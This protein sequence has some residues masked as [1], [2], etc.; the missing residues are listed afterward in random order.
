MLKPRVQIKLIHILEC[1][2]S[3][4]PFDT[5]AI[6]LLL[7]SCSRQHSTHVLVC[8]DNFSHFVVMAP[9][10][11]KTPE[12]AAGM[13][14]LRTGHTTAVLYIGLSV[15]IQMSRDIITLGHNKGSAPRC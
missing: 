14:R 6:D 2:S 1:P 8:V 12:A 11:N 3:A 10:P 4:G 7:L 13:A 5:V 9:L 15:G